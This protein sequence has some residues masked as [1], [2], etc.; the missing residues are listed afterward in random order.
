MR[1]V[2]VMNSEDI[3]SLF[4]LRNTHPDT[5]IERLET[6]GIR[7]LGTIK[8]KKLDRKTRTLYLG[9]IDGQQERFYFNEITSK[10][11]IV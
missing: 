3:A 11:V 6:I 9:E 10:I 1:R 7:T 4:M 5:A 8:C 2:Q